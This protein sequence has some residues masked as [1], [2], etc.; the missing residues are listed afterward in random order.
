MQL[1]I[2]ELI[3][4]ALLIAFFWLQQRRSG[5]R[6]YRLWCL[7]WLCVLASYVVWMLKPAGVLPRQMQFAVRYDLSLLGAL[8]FL[9][10]L[11]PRVRQRGTLMLGVAVGLPVVAVLNVQEF[12]PV[13]KVC[14]LLA[15]SAW[16]VY[17][18][19]AA[20]R[21]L[22][23]FW[24][25]RRRLI[26]AIV[27]VF[28][29]GLLAHV[30]RY[31]GGNPDLSDFALAEVMLCAG[32]LY[33]PGQGRRSLAS[34]AGTLGFAVWASFYMVGMLLQLLGHWGALH[35][36]Y[37]FWNLPKYFVAFSMIL[38][39]SEDA[40]ERQSGLAE[41]FQQMYE[42]FRLL[43]EQHPHPMWIYDPQTGR[44]LSANR[45]TEATY[46]YAA[47]ELAGMPLGR[48]ELPRDAEWEAMEA[49]FPSPPDG[50]RSRH[51]RS[52]GTPVW[53]NV[54]E[55]DVIFQGRPARVVLSRDVTA[56]LE[57]NT[58]LARRAQH[59]EL[60][61]LPN[62]LL[63]VERVEQCLARS[64]RDRLRSVLF[65]ID[66]DHF[67]RVNDTYGH[68]VGDACLRAVAERLKS[69]IRQADTLARTG[70]EEFMAMVGGLQGGERT[71]VGTD[72]RKVAEQLLHCFD[73]PLQCEGRRLAVT[74]SIGAAVYP[75]DGEDML[76][77]RRRSDEAL[78]TAKHLGRNRVVFASEMETQIGEAEALAADMEADLDALLDMGPAAGELTR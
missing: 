29:L 33:A 69:R 41:Q 54:Y 45:A 55:R 6:T 12:Q 30:W 70:G 26:R 37:G 4:M 44:L 52:D 2:I 62:R 72:A 57:S 23:V 15:V 27:V 60:T 75:E 39:V 77:L 31:T 1:Q 73:E 17:G 34:V 51:R 47:I 36:L 68:L 42:D 49:V 16:H 8:V 11:L 21:L 76:T 10:S 32:V 35:I 58:E 63:L 40:R 59:D 20:E 71:D 78:Y 65:T 56:Q 9:M 64:R 46:G 19:W 50:R 66:V 38:K 48:L 5:E 13:P 61:G 18:L 43:Y 24:V 14:V 67:K 28:G 74:I 25:R 22:P 7:G 53:V 3:Q